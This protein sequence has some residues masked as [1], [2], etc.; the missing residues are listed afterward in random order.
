MN[1]RQWLGYE[2]PENHLSEVDLKLNEILSQFQSIFEKYC[3]IDASLSLADLDNKIDNSLLDNSIY[4]GF[5]DWFIEEGKATLIGL[6]NNL[7]KDDEILVEELNYLKFILTSE[8]N[9]VLDYPEDVIG[10]LVDIIDQIGVLL[11]PAIKVCELKKVTSKI[12]FKPE[13]IHCQDYLLED[14]YKQITLWG[15]Y[16]FMEERDSYNYCE[17]P[18]YIQ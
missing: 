14:I 3:N 4:R 12:V 18:F 17:N 13:D 8:S 11:S 16:G 5:V 10:T 7:Y 2:V 15:D 6:G 9:N 1:I